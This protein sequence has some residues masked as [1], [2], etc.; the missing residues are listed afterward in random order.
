MKKVY[1]LGVLLSSFLIVGCSQKET[2]KESSQVSIVEISTTTKETKQSATDSKS[3]TSSSESSW[4]FFKSVI[5]IKWYG[6][7]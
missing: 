1:L 7:K 5:S 3:I 4:N 2:T 6:P